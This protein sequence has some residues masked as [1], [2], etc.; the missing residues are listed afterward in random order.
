MRLG[1][2][3]LRE[4]RDDAKAKGQRWKALD[5]DPA[6]H[7]L[8]RR[9]QSSVGITAGWRCAKTTAEREISPPGTSLFES[10]LS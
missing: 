4:E 5:Y 3:V 2:H 10:R 7:H 8:A 9:A 6:A 1:S